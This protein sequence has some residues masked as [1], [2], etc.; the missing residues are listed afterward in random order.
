[1]GLNNPWVSNNDNSSSESA[2]LAKEVSDYVNSVFPGKHITPAEFRRILP[3]LIWNN[4]DKVKHKSFE[5]FINDYA[6]LVNTSPKVSFLL[7][8][9]DCIFKLYQRNSNK[10]IEGNNLQSARNCT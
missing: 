10:K 7:L 9:V 8:T 5:D 3:T 2:T 6:G 1:M 4:E